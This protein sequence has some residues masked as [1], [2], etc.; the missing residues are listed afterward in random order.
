MSTEK[1]ASLN[2][3]G[4]I[5][6]N[7]DKLTTSSNPEYYFPDFNFVKEATTDAYNASGMF[8]NNISVDLTVNDI[9]STNMLGR[10]DLTEAEI[11]SGSNDVLN[12]ADTTLATYPRSKDSH[13]KYAKELWRLVE[14]V[15]SNKPLDILNKSENKIYI[16]TTKSIIE[17][18]AKLYKNINYEQLNINTSTTWF[19]YY[20]NGLK[21]IIDSEKL[22]ADST[23]YSKYQL[24]G[25]FPTE[26]K[27]N[28]FK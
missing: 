12:I 5:G 8:L 24:I 22:K 10:K 3:I 7:I 27:A 23:L 14:Y 2:I 26:E 1:E 18:N 28:S 9:K 20:E 15:D 25:P 11:L 13:N 6:Y 17:N 21:Y 16:N 4:V 19:V